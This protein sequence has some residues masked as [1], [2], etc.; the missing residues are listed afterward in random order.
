MKVGRCGLRKQMPCRPLSLPGRGPRPARA[1]APPQFRIMTGGRAVAV[2]SLDLADG[3]LKVA[4]APKG[5]KEGERLSICGQ[6]AVHSGSVRQRL[7]AR[8]ECTRRLARLQALSS[9]VPHHGTKLCRESGARWRRKTTKRR[10]APSR[11]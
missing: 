1:L 2:K 7:A 9:R 4:A 5:L 3:H 10:S 8:R 11:R 6:F